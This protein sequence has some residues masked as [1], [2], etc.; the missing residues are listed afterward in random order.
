MDGSSAAEF[1]LIA[2]LTRGL[3]P[4]PD[5]A[6]GVGDDCAI[7]DLNGDTLLLATSDSQVEGVH[8]TRQFSSPE[9]IGRK[10]LS[11]NLSDIA[12]MG[13]EPRY[14]LVSLILPEDL[15]RSYI[16]TLYAGIRHE[17]SHYATAIIGGNISSA[18]ESASFVIDITLLGTIERGRAITRSGAQSGDT[19]MVT[20]TLGDSAAGLYTL[21]HPSAHYPRNAQEVLRKV[22]RIPQPRIRVG[23]VLSQL[24]PAIIT[25]MLD[26]SDGCSGDLAHLCERS[27]VG[28]RVELALLPLSPFIRA[29][30]ASIG[31]DPF[32]WALHGGEDYELL[33]TVS[34]G[35]EQGVIE[36]V[37]TATGISVTSIGT[38]LP[39]DEGMK[40]V[41]P[42]GHEDV[43]VIQSWNHLKH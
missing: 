22:H 7:L 19:L 10:A 11:V 12:A 29:V 31:Y 13:G 9:Q 30:A 16:D 40:V 20:N 14:A 25:A 24:G 5:V 8:F 6:L 41:Y 35:H 39:P 26:V 1:E 36:A 3:P 37:H 27:N 34:P 15:S 2:H 32:L 28:A 42:D 33:F 4:R 18:G 43:L 38:M 23:R 21:L 17:A